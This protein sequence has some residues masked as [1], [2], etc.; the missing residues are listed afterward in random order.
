MKQAFVAFALAFGLLCAAKPAKATNPPRAV[1]DKKVGKT[2]ISWQVSPAN[3][4]IFLDGKKV[5]EAG[6]AKFTETK[7]GKHAVKL[8]KDK[9]ETEMDIDVHKGEVKTFTFEFT[10]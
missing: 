7:P 10:D 5:G 8:V 1:A 4:V 9:D 2:G 3:V 6:A